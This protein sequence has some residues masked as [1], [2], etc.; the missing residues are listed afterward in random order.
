MAGREPSLGF[1]SF[2]RRSLTALCR[3]SPCKCKLQ[4]NFPKAAIRLLSGNVQVQMSVVGI[5]QPLAAIA[6]IFLTFQYHQHQGWKEVQRKSGT[7]FTVIRDSIRST[8][9]SEICA[10]FFSTHWHFRLENPSGLPRYRAFVS[11]S[12]SSTAS[13][14]FIILVSINVFPVSPIGPW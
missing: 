3:P 12:G 13:K 1:Q 6:R 9:A 7:T 4:G 8:T 5:F 14:A 10:Y 11:N 2:C